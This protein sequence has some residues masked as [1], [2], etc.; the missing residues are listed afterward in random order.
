[1][2]NQLRY[3]SL[4]TRIVMLVVIISGLVYWGKWAY[5]FYD[6]RIVE[7]LDLYNPQGKDTCYILA[8]FL[9]FFFGTLLTKSYRFWICTLAISCPVWIFI[10]WTVHSYV[11]FYDDQ[12]GSLGKVNKFGLIGAE[13]EH[14]IMLFVT[15]YLAFVGILEILRYYGKLKQNK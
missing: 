3:S 1:M 11:I 8:S 14:I 12:I 10:N 13:C 2:K 4:A 7:G 9:T 5:R 6:G 15:I